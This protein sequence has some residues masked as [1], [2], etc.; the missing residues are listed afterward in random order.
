MLTATRTDGTSHKMVWLGSLVSGVTALFLT[1]DSVIH[2]TRLA[3]VVEAFTKLG[4]PLGLAA[5]LG[6]IELVCVLIYLHPRACVLGA[7]LL[8]GYL[9]GAVAM[10]L[11]VG[12]PLFGET[13]FPVYVGVLAWA[14]VYLRE[15]R[16]GALIPLLG[17][18]GPREGAQS[19]PRLWGGR[20]ASGLAALMM[21][22]ASLPK[23]LQAPPVIE[24]FRQL[25][26]PESLVVTVGV[27]ELVCTVAYVLPPTQVLGAILMTGV[28]GGATA[29][30]VR[31]GNPDWLVT[32]TLGLLV[33]GGLFLR[34]ERVRALIPVRR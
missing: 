27:I 1:F 10:Q 2:M 15:R 5:G 16:L 3:P 26:Y 11:R 20:I 25:G 24:G 8:T 31:V 23:L 33:W 18:G 19:K 17:P 28:L 13:L 32:V 30:N 4:F 22:F 9:G 7:I 6:I 34:M 14:G 21:L 29:T 12:N